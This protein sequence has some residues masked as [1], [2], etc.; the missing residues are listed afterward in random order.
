M[1]TTNRPSRAAKALSL[2]AL[3]ATGLAA[4]APADEED[5]ATTPSQTSSATATSSPADDCAPERMPTIESN[6]L[7]IATDQPAYE[8]WMVDDDPTNGEGFEAAVA[9]AVAEW[10][11]YSEDNVVW[12]RVPFNAAIQPGP[13]A[14][15]FDINQFTITRKRSKAVDFSAP[16]YTAVQAVV[17][18]GTSPAAGA[19]SLADLKPLR[20]GAQV[21]TTSLDAVNDVIAPDA[22]AQVFNTNDDAK[23]ALENGQVDA[24]VVDLPTAFYITSAELTDGKI[25]GQLPDT[26]LGGDQF[27]LVL[28]KASPLTPCITTAVMALTQDG[29]LA[30]L[31]ERWLSNVADAPILE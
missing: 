7:T 26:S 15:D 23:L 2:L 4:C 30:E 12:T 20:I 6:I 8:P 25:V 24:I 19:T 11:G 13:K 5:A 28:D 17:T 29:T 3:L 18:T 16:Y 27:G 9:Y 31:E 10:L 21:A 22:G 1:R 14:F